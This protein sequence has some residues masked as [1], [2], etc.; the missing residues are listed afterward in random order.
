MTTTF[1]SDEEQWLYQAKKFNEN[2][3][4]YKNIRAGI[5]GIT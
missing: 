5:G 2:Y 1:D 3:R 4:I